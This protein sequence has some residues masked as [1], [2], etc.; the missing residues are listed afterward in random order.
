MV[1]EKKSNKVFLSFYA[2]LQQE[3]RHVTQWCQHLK[4]PIS[5]LRTTPV[6]KTQVFITSAKEVMFLPDFLCLTVCL[7]LLAR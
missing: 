4:N 7:S 3:L 1:A 6:C 5:L 2:A